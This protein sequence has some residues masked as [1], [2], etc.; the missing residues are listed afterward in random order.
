MEGHKVFKFSLPKVHKMIKKMLD[1]NNINQLYIDMLIP[2]QASGPG[3][4][5]YSKI[6]GFDEQKVMN[7]IDKTGNCVAASIPLALSMAFEQK[8]ISENNLIMLVP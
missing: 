7:I 3:V 5:A 1:R 4:V 8:L 6:G 2:H